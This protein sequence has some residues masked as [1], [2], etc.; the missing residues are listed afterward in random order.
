[1]LSRVADSLYWLSRYLER[2][3][4]TA[5]VAGVHL[6]LV[7]EQPAEMN[8]GRWARV[9]QSL[10]IEE[11]GTAPLGTSNVL[12]MICYNPASRPSVVH[13]VMAARFNAR[14]VRE[15]ISSEMWEQMNRLYHQ[16]VG[17][18][19]TINSD[20]DHLAFLDKV[21]EGAQHF[22]GMTDSTMTHG[23]GW[24]FIELGRYLERA[25]SIARLLE[26]HL[27]HFEA[28]FNAPGEEPD[29]LPYPEWIGL[30][31]S[32]TAFEAYCKVHTPAVLPRLVADFLVLSDRFPHSV[33][34][35]LDR[36]YGALAAIAE[37]APSQRGQ[38]VVRVAGR[39]RAMLGYSQIDE[40]L[41]QGL[42]P[43]LASIREECDAVHSGLHQAFIGYPVEAALGV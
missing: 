43:A 28:N 36:V 25:Q 1:M 3:E 30:L 13:C 37:N 24:R 14:Q 31:K 6:N 22:M 33:R 26:T 2:A 38:T 18:D 15:E 40:L 9:I 20:A 7:P 17:A 21:K 8:L 5:R 12:D 4:H 10:G 23:E 11:T 35:S 27:T 34:F 41:G 19:P 32:A 29:A 42:G 39:Q 16:V